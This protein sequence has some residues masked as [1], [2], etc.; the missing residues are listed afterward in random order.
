MEQNSS[1]IQIVIVVLIGLLAVWYVARKVRK[2][3]KGGGCGCGC[4]CGCEKHKH[5]GSASGEMNEEK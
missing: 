5:E 2:T 1:V 4:G 3:V